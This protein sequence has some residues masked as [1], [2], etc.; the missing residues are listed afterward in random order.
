MKF[1]YKKVK[2]MGYCKTALAFCNNPLFLRMQKNE[3][4]CKDL[5]A[6]IEILVLFVACF[7]VCTVAVLF[8]VVKVLIVLHV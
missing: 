4:F 3:N 7:I 1:K 8:A 6:V 5:L 2:T